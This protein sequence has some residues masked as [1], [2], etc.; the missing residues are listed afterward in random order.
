[1]VRFGAL[2]A[3]ASSAL[4]GVSALVKKP[5]ETDW[6][7]IVAGSDGWFNYRHQAD[8]CHAYQIASSWGIPDERIIVMHKD[9][10]AQS[11]SNPF[12]GEVF[13]KPFEE[14]EEGFEVYKTCPKDYTGSDVTPENFMA[15]MTGDE[16]AA[17]GKKV[18][19]SGPKDDVFV[20]WT[21]HGG[22]GIIAFPTSYLHVND[23]TKTLKTMHD[24]NM[25]KKL[26]FYLEACESGSMFEKVLPD[27][28]NIYAT[29]ASSPYESSWATYCPPY[30]KVKGKSI[31]SCLGDLYSVN[32]M[33]EV[34][35]AGKAET[36]QENFDVTKKLTTQSKVMQWGDVSFVDEEIG[37]FLADGET[38][39]QVS[40]AAR[41]AALREVPKHA[42]RAYDVPLHLAYYQYLRA[43][44]SGDLEEAA[45]ASQTL[46]KEVTHRQESVALFKRM[47]TTMY[48]F[49]GD[50]KMLNSALASP[51]VYPSMCGS[52]CV[53]AYEKFS[54]AC[55]GWTE[56]NRQF[57]KVLNNACIAFQ[58]EAAGE[59]VDAAATERVAAAIDAVCPA[60]E[61]EKKN[62]LRWA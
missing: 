3:I 38:K 60:P 37:D 27:D 8:T 59:N 18:L 30:D 5:K 17:N 24:K 15:V 22:P 53:S 12:P 52:C 32:W 1:M 26:V 50:Q 40:E 28:M 2:A 56:F 34:E 35:K 14:T 58:T 6:V 48:G 20:Y 9:D 61:V 42:V 16:K 55:G 19:K 54:E 11:R 49:Q 21:D 44:E 31:G 62:H 57:M 36:L 39:A 46:S 47:L 33:E 23:L 45:H 25:Y 13:N 51:A 7:V 41:K 10:I 4:V 29:S 43:S